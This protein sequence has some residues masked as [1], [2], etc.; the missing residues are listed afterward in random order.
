MPLPAVIFLALHLTLLQQGLS[1]DLDFLHPASL[2][3]PWAPGPI[4]LLR[5]ALPFAPVPASYECLGSGACLIGTAALPDAS[6]YSHYIF[7]K[8][9]NYVSPFLPQSLPYT[10]LLVSV[11][12]IASFFSSSYM[13]PVQFSPNNVLCMYRIWAGYLVLD[14]QLEGPYLMKTT[15]ITFYIPHCLYVVLCQRLRPHKSFPLW[16]SY[17]LVLSV[18]TSC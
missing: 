10:L 11:K 18:F 2:S 3:G 8:V 12:F 7:L 5:P 4:C 6:L 13:Q 17:P 9:H 16:C 15:F 1:L 14:N